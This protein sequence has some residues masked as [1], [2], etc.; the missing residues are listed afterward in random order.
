M[1]EVSKQIRERPYIPHISG[2][3]SFTS[4]SCWRKQLTDR[5]GLS[6]ARCLLMGD[7]LLHV[8]LRLVPYSPLE[9]VRYDCTFALLWRC[10]AL[11]FSLGLFSLLPVMSQLSLVSNLYLDDLSNKTRSKPVPWEVRPRS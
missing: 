9:N 7:V 4:G 8:D 3:T 5:H 10:L 1:G 2:R 6:V 11:S